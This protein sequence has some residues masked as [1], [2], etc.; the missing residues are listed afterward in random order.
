MRRQAAGQFAGNKIQQ[1]LGSDPRIQKAGAH[2]LHQ[3][4]ELVARQLQRLGHE[5]ITKSDVGGPSEQ[6]DEGDRRKAAFSD[7][8][9]R[10]AV[11]FG[12]G[13]YLYRLPNQWLDYDPQRRQFA[14]PPTLPAWALPAKE[15]PTAPTPAKPV[16]ARQPANGEDL[17][18]RLQDYDARLAAQ[19]LSCADHEAQLRKFLRPASPT[20]GAS[21]HDAPYGRVVNQ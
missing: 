12:I 3:I 13:R 15:S 19:G 4:E 5:W 21:M 7:A 1:P 16:A 10:A 9:K 6:P 2:E 17:Q 14:R 8:L 20:R 18:R 11:K